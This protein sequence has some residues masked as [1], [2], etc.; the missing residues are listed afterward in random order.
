LG[1][2][3]QGIIY[4]GTIYKND[5]ATTLDELAPAVEKYPLIAS[6]IVPGVELPKSRLDV[7]QAG[8]LLYANY[9]KLA[10]IIKNK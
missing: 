9:S 10:G 1:P 7:K 6:L 3:I 5:K 2:S 4:G 8:S